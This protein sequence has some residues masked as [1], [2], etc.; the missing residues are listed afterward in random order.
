[1][2]DKDLEVYEYELKVKTKE[3]FLVFMEKLIED[4]EKNEDKWENSNLNF[5]LQA[6][7]AWVG[8]MDGAYTNFGLE[9]PQNV[10][11]DV[12]ARIL[13]AATIYE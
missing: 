7:A 4:Y 6:I 2:I 11:W 13:G 8:D 5:Y 10:S 3:D 9:P 12:F 1:M